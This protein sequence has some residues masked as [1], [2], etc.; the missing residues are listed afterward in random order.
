MWM[1]YKIIRQFDILLFISF[2]IMPKWHNILSI[3][4]FNNYCTIH[5]EKLIL[6]SNYAFLAQL[7]RAVDC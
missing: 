7:V 4:I 6:Q 3:F 2:N 5:L 1:Y